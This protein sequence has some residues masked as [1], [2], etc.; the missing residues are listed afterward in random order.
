M[1]KGKRN[2]ALDKVGY[3]GLRLISPGVI[4][5][6]RDINLTVVIPRVQSFTDVFGL[7]HCATRNPDPI[8]PAL[9]V[10]YRRVSHRPENNPASSRIFWN[11]KFAHRNT[12]LSALFRGEKQSVSMA[13]NYTHRAFFARTRI[14][15]AC[16]AI[17]AKQCG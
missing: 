5:M 3:Y 15:P 6:L 13:S 2:Y 4:R 8:F 1:V 12:R 9:A 10:C 7:G 14:I 17:P 16:R 11:D